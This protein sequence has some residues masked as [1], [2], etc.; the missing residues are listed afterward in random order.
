LVTPFD[1][2]EEGLG[3]DGEAIWE[4]DG[5]IADKGR[6]AIGDWRQR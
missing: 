1:L 3:H 6:D 4:P 2:G 5:L